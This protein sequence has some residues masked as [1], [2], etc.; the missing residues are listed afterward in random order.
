MGM[1]MT[2]MLLQMLYMVVGRVPRELSKIFWNFMTGGGQI[3]CE[4]KEGERVRGT[5][6]CGSQQLYE[7][8]SEVTVCS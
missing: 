6:F 4:V 8:A 3:E 5:L 2:A 1:H 7:Q